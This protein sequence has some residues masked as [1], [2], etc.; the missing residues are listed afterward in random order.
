MTNKL[1][2]EL[3][4][5]RYD[6]GNVHQRVMFTIRKEKSNRINRRCLLFL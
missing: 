4:K 6:W 1:A 5:T 2:T 3:L